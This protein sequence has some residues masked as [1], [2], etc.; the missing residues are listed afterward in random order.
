MR[1]PRGEAPGLAPERDGEYGWTP[2]APRCGF[3]PQS[4]RNPPITRPVSDQPAPLWGRVARGM[5]VENHSRTRPCPQPRQ[6]NTTGSSFFPRGRYPIISISFPDTE[7]RGCGVRYY[8]AKLS[9]SR[10]PNTARAVRPFWR[11]VPETG[12]AFRR[13][14][15]DLV[16]RRS[17][18]SSPFCPQ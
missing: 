9:V 14:V 18:T 16:R 4:E 7:G 13:S 8:G 6:K 3:R 10:G 5:G 17:C 1:N 2:R 15:A 12:G 11:G